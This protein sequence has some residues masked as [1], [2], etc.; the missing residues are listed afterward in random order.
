MSI[1][2]TVWSLDEK[3]PL[4]Y[5]ELKDEKEL[6]LLILDNIEILNKGWLVLSNQVKTDAGKYIDVLCMDHDG[7]LVVVELKR[8]MTPR[9][10]TAQVIDY[11]A[12]VS[13]L[14]VEEIAQLYLK[15]SR[16]TKT[17]NEAYKEK[18]GADLDEEHVN[19]NVKMVIVAAQMDKGTERIIQFLRNTYQV[20]INILFFQVFQCGAQRLISRAWFQEDVEEAVP[21]GNSAKHL[22]NGEYYASFGTYEGGRNWE[23]AIKYGF[24][25]AGHGEWYSKTL[26]LL[27]VGDRVWVNIPHTGYVGVGIVTEPM[28]RAKEV[29][30]EIDGKVKTM[31]DLSLIGGDYFY[32]EDD[33][34]N[35]EYIV[36]VQWIKTVPEEEAIKELGF[37]GNQNSVCRPHNEKW[38]F[39]IERLKKYWNI[40]D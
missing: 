10:V 24:I 2:H 6:E 28:K 19:E 13:K 39:T 1:E 37:F 22:W 25:S 27:S 31:R 8:D 5:A 9:E 23:D 26:G 12:S 35:A 30:F 18:F 14:T 33:P 34:E 7:D 20:D 32:K 17:L 3:K 36:K 11:A 21:T 40:A 4:T 15:Q 38:E 16:E 29:V